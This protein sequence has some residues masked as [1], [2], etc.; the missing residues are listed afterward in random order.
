MPRK[1][2]STELFQLIR[3]LNANEKG[4]F[5]KYASRHS[6]KGNEYFRLFSAIDKMEEY[7]ES[8]L[9]K[10]INHL[11]VVKVYLYNLLMDALVLYH[12]TEKNISLY[13]ANKYARTYILEMKGLSDK[14]I[15]ERKQARTVAAKHHHT[16]F[17]Y[18]FARTY[19]QLNNIKLGAYKPSA[20]YKEIYD[21]L[22]A[23]LQ[24]EQMHLRYNYEYG[25]LR[26]LALKIKGEMKDSVTEKDV[27]FELLKTD[28]H[29]VHIN[30]KRTS[31]EALINYYLKKN[32]LKNAYQVASQYLKTEKRLKRD[33]SNVHFYSRAVMYAAMA[34]MYN[35]KYNEAHTLLNQLGALKTT[36]EHVNTLNRMRFVNFKLSNF[37]FADDYKAGATFCSSVLEKYPEQFDGDNPVYYYDGNIIYALYLLFFSHN[38]EKCISLYIHHIKHSYL[39]KKAPLAYRDVE[40]FWLMIQTELGNY[41]LLP[42]LTK[43]TTH[44]FKKL[45]LLQEHTKTLLDFFSAVGTKGN[46]VSTSKYI[47][48][49]RDIYNKLP[50]DNHSQHLISGIKPYEHWIESLPMHHRKH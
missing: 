23:L 9:K 20:Y 3:S 19:H 25:K 37:C 16:G 17:E 39:Q 49:L 33:I 7:D 26:A 10:T 2:G 27:D 36:N 29:L 40:L 4:F 42:A 18:L 6:E 11:P 13:L 14:A 35:S 41:H 47:K 5:K 45:H 8:Y 15:K 50:A 30:E 1:S 12:N 38:F 48:L 31:S 21:E 28:S 46:Q 32:E 34:A 44:K 24:R 43:S 22:S